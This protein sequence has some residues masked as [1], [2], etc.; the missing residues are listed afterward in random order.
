M[1]W[2]SEN[3]QWKHIDMRGHNGHSNVFSKKKNRKTMWEVFVSFQ[4]CASITHIRNLR[5]HNLNPAAYHCQN[6]CIEV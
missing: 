2:N 4:M 1:N 6:R 3:E 5:N